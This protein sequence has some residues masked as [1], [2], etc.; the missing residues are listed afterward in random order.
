[1]IFGHQKTL[2]LLSKY[3]S[4]QKINQ[5]KKLSHAFLFSG[6]KNIGKKT[7]AFFLAKYIEGSHPFSFLEFLSK[8]CQC[9]TCRQIEKGNYPAISIV[10][11]EEEKKQIGIEEI[12]EIRRTVSLSSPFPFKIV[13]IDEAHFLSQEAA[14]ALLK[15]LEEPKGDTIFFLISSV[16]S[17]LP[18][19][20]LSRVEI[21][22]FFPL[23]RQEIFQFLQ[24]IKIEE[25]ISL[26]DLE[27][28]KILDLSLG[29]PAI[30]KKLLLDKTEF[31][32]YNL[33]VKKIEKLLSLD[34]FSR[35]KL[36]QTIEKRKRIEDFL[37][38]LEFWFRD[39][40]LLKIG[41]EEKIS[42]LSWRE[43]LKKQAQE[44]EETKIYQSLKEIRKVK[45]LLNYSSISKILAL[46]NLLLW[47]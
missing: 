30:A 44:I 4:P 15:T 46:E 41:N 26:T 22:R 16:P 33:L 8:N 32:N 13:I 19:T 39:L 10:S 12:R 11:K 31:D 27:E 14:G 1:M 6:P 21:F 24:K 29:R 43:S 25:R 35:L 37:F 17:F 2:K 45:N 47:L 42:F 36:A 20:I 18:K 5:K 23:S 28:T 34:T 38:L 3:F 7:I 40:M 9:Q